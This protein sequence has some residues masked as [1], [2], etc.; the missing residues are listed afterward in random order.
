MGK[1]KNTFSNQQISN[2]ANKLSSLQIHELIN[3][4]LQTKKSIKTQKSYFV[5][6]KQFFEDFQIYEGAQLIQKLSDHS[7]SEDITNFINSHKKYDP[8]NP[9]R[10]LNPRTINRKA[11]SLSSFFKFLQKRFK[12]NYNPVIFEPASTPKFSETNSLN[13][14]ELV[15]FLEYLKEKYK[16]S[17]DKKIHIHLR[18]YLIF[19]FMF[20]SLRR[21]EVSQLRRE[22]I[23]FEEQY[24]KVLQ[25]GGTNK[26]IPLPEEFFNK[27]MQF[28]DIKESKKIESDYIFTPFYN[29]KTKNFEKPLTSE[30]IYNLT[31]KQW[32]KYKNNEELSQIYKEKDKLKNRKKYLNKKLKLSKDKK[33]ENEIRIVE[34]KIEQLN[35]RKKR[36]LQTTKSISC[37][38]FRKSFVE[39][40]ILR[41]D[42]FVEIQNATGH[43]GPAMIGYYQSI[44]KTKHNSANKMSDIF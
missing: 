9:N 42:D 20:F 37:H 6:L 32:I 31:L 40:A 38:S 14:E 1:I 3:I 36:L 22:D 30:Y 13:K 43:S 8:Q 33:I 25:K 11:Y 29:N 39:Q 18:N 7:I 44:S 17:S 27:L 19:G 15:G 16:K 4:F 26:Y 5:D 21:S 35:I 23:N 41:G 28:K 24:I 12:V 10:L 2:P 34:E